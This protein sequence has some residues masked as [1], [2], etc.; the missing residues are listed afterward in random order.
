MEVMIDGK[1]EH[2]IIDGIENNF[3]KNNNYKNVTENRS[4]NLKNRN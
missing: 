2:L 1:N 4:S 3:K